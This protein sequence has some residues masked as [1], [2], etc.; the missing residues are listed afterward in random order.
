MAE[1]TGVLLQTVEENQNILFTET[2]ICPTRCITHREG[3]GIVRVN[4]KSTSQQRARYLVSFSGNI[5]IPADGTVG[6][7]SVAIAI[8]GEPLASTEMIVT[9]AAVENFLNVSSQVYI[10]V[11]CGCCV[12]VAVQN[13][14]DKAIE[15][16][17]ANLIVVRVA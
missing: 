9:P 17:N 12:T 13:T 11:S 1:F 10:D 16:Q 3:S 14:S 5:Q 4:G 6:E 7:I 2:P 15:V 8:D